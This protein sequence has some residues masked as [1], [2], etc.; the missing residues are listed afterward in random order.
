MV[1]IRV[2][3]LA[4]STALVL[5]RPDPARAGPKALEG[6][7]RCR[8]ALAR[9]GARAN[10]RSDLVRFRSGTAEAEP[11]ASEGPRHS[12]SALVGPGDVAVGETDLV[13]GLPGTARDGLTS[14]TGPR[15]FPTLQEW[16]SSGNT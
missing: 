13:L 8:S 14:L 12:R 3:C 10:D 5:A 7:C 4:G 1:C 9:P 11:L 15:R 16:L 6:S 2:G